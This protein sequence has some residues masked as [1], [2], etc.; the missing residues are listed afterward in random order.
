MSSPS[1]FTWHDI[2]WLHLLTVSFC[3]EVNL[4]EMFIVLYQR[5]VD[6]EVQSSPLA[7]SYILLAHLPI[8]LTL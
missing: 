8:P 1:V 6:P 5:E 3:V 2:R 4:E 7:L